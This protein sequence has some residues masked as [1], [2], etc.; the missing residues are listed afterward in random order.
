MHCLFRAAALIKPTQT[1]AGALVVK[2]FSTHSASYDAAL[3]NTPHTLQQPAQLPLFS[4]QPRLPTCPS[5][6][7]QPIQPTGTPVGDLLQHL[8]HPSSSHVNHEL[9]HKAASNSAASPVPQNLSYKQHACGANTC[10]S[11]NNT[12]CLY[13][14]QQHST[15]STATRTNS[16]SATP[17]PA[18]LLLKVCLLLAS[19][20]RGACLHTTWDEHSGAFVCDLPT[21][22]NISHRVPV[23][24][25]PLRGLVH[26]P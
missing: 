24:T 12:H 26:R 23:R 20:L 2:E 17:A 15:Q 8:E 13:L 19:T 18:N 1:C 4:H 6:F 9:H 16:S 10:I 21:F 14:I 3:T 7:Q 22:H 11:R 5:A 25:C